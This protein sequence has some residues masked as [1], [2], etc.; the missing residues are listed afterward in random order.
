MHSQ[1][2]PTKY[3]GVFFR[4]SRRIGEQGQERVFYIVFK[5]DGKVFE[6]KA[7]RQ[8]ADD[9]TAARAARVRAE[10]IEGKR[11]SRKELREAAQ[12]QK[13]AWTIDKLWTEYR[14]QRIPKGIAQDQSRFRKYISP[15]LGPKQPHE[16]MPLDVDRLRVKVLEKKSPQTKNLTLALL[17]R[18]VNFGVDEKLSSPLPFRMR[19][20][21]VHNIVTEDLRPE[22]VS[23]LLHVLDSESDLQARNLM[24]LALFTGMRRGELFK[25][26]WEHVDFERGFIHIKDPKGGPDQIIPMNETARNTLETHPRKGAFVFPGRGGLQRKEIR[27]PVNRIKAAAG[28]PADF[29]P[30]HGLRHSFASMLASSG[31]VDM[32]TLQKLLTH[33]SPGMTQRYAHLRDDALKNASELAGRIIEQTAKQSEKAQ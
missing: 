12:A 2:F 15:H 19:L 6:E 10:R 11:P 14:K 13:E 30:L 32:Y 22:Q 27:R 26:R 16:I 5:K 23:K 31:Q 25:L 9:M 8:Y 1:R 29:R 24:K 18:I 17:R 33:K 28:L 20:P 3:P 21:Q 4:L 7:G